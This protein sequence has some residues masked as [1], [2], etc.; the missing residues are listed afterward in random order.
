MECTYVRPLLYR[1]VEDQLLPDDTAAIQT[2]LSGCEA[3]SAR[4]GKIIAIDEAVLSAED[5]LPSPHL[6]QKL[7]VDYQRLITRKTS[8]QPSWPVRFSWMRRVAAVVLIVFGS[9]TATWFAVRSDFRTTSTEILSD[10]AR[11]SLDHLFPL[12]LSN[13]YTV[14]HLNGQRESGTRIHFIQ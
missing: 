5:E 12:V 6:R 7:L 14:M 9:S 2:H 10:G 8:N 3:C 13:P 4:T 11:V 1:F